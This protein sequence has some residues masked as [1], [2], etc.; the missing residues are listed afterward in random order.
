M[1]ILTS[2]RVSCLLAALGACATATAESR[3]FLGAM[4]GVATLSGDA[5]SQIG[6]GTAAVSLYKPEN[7]PTLQF[8]GG[9]HLS[10]YASVQANY[11]WNRNDVLLTS[12]VTAGGTAQS[13]QQAR[14]SSQHG[15]SGDLL[16]YFR[17]RQSRVRPFLAIGLGV[18]RFHST[19][20]APGTVSQG[21]AP[22][23]AVF[24]STALAVRF[25][26]GIDVAL[27]GGWFLR[28]SFT[29][30]MRQNPVSEQ[31][32]PPGQRRMAIFQNLFGLVKY[33]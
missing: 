19:A 2:A 9:L 33:F 20:T 26:V 21:L 25:P 29:E 17:D 7:G 22:P 24:T 27:H 1:R 28:Y 31:L 5:R 3:Y 30:I 18:I 15:A 11:V 8:F 10:N 4:G 23:P 16:I 12:L 32:S 13:Y 14:E 6:S